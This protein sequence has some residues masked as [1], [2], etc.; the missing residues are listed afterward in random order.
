MEEQ[1]SLRKYFEGQYKGTQSFRENVIYPIFGKEHFKDKFDNPL[2]DEEEDTLDLRAEAKRAGILSIAHI[3]QIAIQKTNP[4]EVFDFE[5]SDRRSL[6]RCRVGVSRIINRMLKTHTSAFMIFHYAGHSD[7]EWRFSFSHKGA[8]NT[9]M[10][11]G[12]RFTFMLGPGQSCRTAAENFEKLRDKA[13]DGTL[14]ATDIEAAF[15]VDA[16]TQAFYRELAGWFQRAV[17]QDSHITFPNDTS[18]E[19]DDREGLEDK[20]IRLITRVMF[21]WF[22]RQKGL[23]PNWI[24][25]VKRLGEILKEFDPASETDGTYYNA[26]LQNLF[27]ATLNHAIDSDKTKGRRFATNAKADIKTLYRYAELFNVGEDE[28]ISLFGTVPFLNGGLFECQDKTKTLHGVKHAINRDGFSRNDSR[29]ADG[30]FKHRAVVPNALF[31]APETGLFSILGRYNFTI[32]ENS[33]D[34]Q[35]VALDPELLGKVFENLLGLYNP[36][37]RETA[38]NQSGS[39]YT[40]RAI[41]SY[42]VDESLMAYLGDTPAAR[43]LLE[44]TFT[45]PEGEAETYAEMAVRLRKVKILDPACGSGAFPMGVLARMVDILGRIDPEAASDP[46]RLKMDIIENCIFGSD[47]QCIA[48]Q[49]TKLRFFISLICD[50]ERDDAKP[51]YGIPTLPNLETKF[52][53]ADTLVAIGRQAGGAAHEGN[54]FGWSEVADLKDELRRVRHEH[55]GARTAYQKTKLRERDEAL[56]DRLATLLRG[57]GYN[58]M[59]DAA[60]MAEWNPYDQN[61]TAP[62]FD[63]EWMFGVDTGFD[64]V[65]GN[66]PYIQLQAGGGELANRYEGCGYKTFARTGDIYCLFFERGHQLLRRGGHLCFIT[67]NKWM[68]AGYGEKTRGF[69]AKEAN[70]KLLVDFA[71]VKVF[72]SATVDTNILLFGREENAGETLCAVMTKMGRDSVGRL[73]DFVRENSAPCRFAKSES[74]VILSPIEQSIRRKIEKVGTPLKDWDINIYR[75]V[76]TGYND[77]FIITTERREEILAQCKTEDERK[78]T[79]ELIRPILRGRDIKRYGY[80]WAGLWLIGTHNGVKGEV[81]RIHIEDYPT[82]KAHLDQFWDKISTRSD[83]GDTPYNLRNCAYWG[84]FS[85]PKIVWKIIGNRLGFALET[86]KMILNNAC[87]ILTCREG[88]LEYLEAMLN[89]NAVLWYSFVTNMN[90]T[91]VGDMQVGAQNINI[92]PIPLHPQEKHELCEYVSSLHEKFDSAVLDKIESLVCDVYGFSDDERSF[93]RQFA[94]NIFE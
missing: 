38:R 12:R 31:F 66:P 92:L 94:K 57:E 89:S 47:I 14:E 62:F 16:L 81:E 22:I 43:R 64:I 90:K 56:R 6:S 61:A 55:F 44:P 76:L 52:V 1:Q 21:V 40:P 7:W 59:A 78:R 29:F 37:T 41:V 5:V 54:L 70:P 71:G 15:S 53:A 79:E 11:D 3:G 42:M 88:G 51:N 24:F 85:L 65:I 67:S 87:Y 45:P 75:G 58:T 63:P 20:V 84:D 34:D 39:F 93:L 33:P 13:A 18:T 86:N 69:L 32:E 26:V 83:K 25:D 73:G 36:E 28:V 48:A 60:M 49:I 68:R 46:Y 91:G 77:A 19:D 72:E 2:L 17:D 80:E 8:G 10:T 27:F 50:C 4:I 74:W 82:V 35:K 9:D 23:V 30:R